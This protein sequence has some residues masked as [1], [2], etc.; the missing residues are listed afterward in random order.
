MISG[1]SDTA[2]RVLRTVRLIALASDSMP[3]IDPPNFPRELQK[4]ILSPR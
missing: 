2:I 4:A 3:W 1:E